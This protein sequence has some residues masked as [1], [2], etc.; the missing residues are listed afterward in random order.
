MTITKVNCD[1]DRSILINLIISDEVCSK[2]INSLKSN[3][4]RSSYARR[5]VDYCIDF[6]SKYGRAPNKDFQ[7]FFND[8]NLCFIDPENDD[9]D[10]D[11]ENTFLKSL[12]KEY[13]ESSKK[14]IHNNI[15]YAVDRTFAFIK[16]RNLEI[17]REQL[18]D[19]L[20]NNKIELAD[21]LLSEYQESKP[22]EKSILKKI[23]E[24]EVKAPEWIIEDLF[25]K[26]STSIIFGDPGTGK[27]FIALDI[28]ASIA[29]GVDYH[30]HRI[31]NN[32][33]VVYIC[34]EGQA[35][36]ARRCRAWE[37]YHEVSLKDY[38]FYILEAPIQISDEK[39]LAPLIQ[40][41]KEI[42]ISDG[43]PSLIII[44]TWA[45]LFGGEENS[46]SDTSKAIAVLD[47]IRAPYKCSVLII[48]HSGI[49]DKT[50]GRGATSL[51]GAV[52]NAFQ[53]KKNN[54]E[55]VMS[56][57]KR[58]DG[59]KPENMAF[60]LNDV[61]LNIKNEHGRMIESA[62]LILDGNYVEEK[63]S[64]SFRG[65]TQTTLDALKEVIAETD[66]KATYALWK[67]K[68]NEHGVKVSTFEGNRKKLIEQNYVLKNR[69][70]F[71]IFGPSY[72]TTTT[73][74]KEPRSK[75]VVKGNEL[76]DYE[77]ANSYQTRSKVVVK[78]NSLNKQLRK[79]YNSNGVRNEKINS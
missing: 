44:D 6:Y 18:G 60:N 14:K 49:A 17:T 75:V 31:R 69:D 61:N 2:V 72:P 78:D 9:A 1:E 65:K 3:I 79:S 58:K 53:V 42:S 25:E 33:P 67:A 21:K 38:P 23:G 73:G 16:R 29:A 66:E 46:N 63:K 15:E 57:T 71:Y 62:V 20:E 8:Q 5:A 48:H 11:L 70:D 37:I 41:L 28:G 43:Q 35:T 39:S 50:R 68:A 30:T 22:V 7:N 64:N 24:L 36:I 54:D 40:E 47:K 27:S 56:S 13:E 10:L 12:S 34:G 55:I 26:D 59:P 74:S 45:R 77:F 52:D 51:N 19:Y 76:G 4:F 32:G